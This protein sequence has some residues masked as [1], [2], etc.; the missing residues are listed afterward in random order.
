MTMNCFYGYH[1]EKY[2]ESVESY[3]LQTAANKLFKN[4]ILLSFTKQIHFNDFQ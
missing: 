2:N 1:S 3:A 4:G